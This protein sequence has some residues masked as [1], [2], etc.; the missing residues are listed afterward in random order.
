MRCKE[1]RFLVLLERVVRRKEEVVEAGRCF[2]PISSPPG[3][4]EGL[5][6]RSSSVDDE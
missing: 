5:V 6:E 4:D 3:L 2:L 1:G